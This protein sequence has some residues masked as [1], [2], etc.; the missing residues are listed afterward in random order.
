MVARMTLVTVACPQTGTG[1][2]LRGLRTRTICY[3]APIGIL[4]PLRSAAGPSTDK[5]T[6][7]IQSS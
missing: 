7:R 6:S 3:G 1:Y 2:T 4:I 5:S